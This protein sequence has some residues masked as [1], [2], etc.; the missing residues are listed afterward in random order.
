MID[1]ILSD[2]ARALG[3]QLGRREIERFSTYTSLLL[4][5]NEKFNLTA[6]TDPVEI[7]VKHHLDSL[8]CL[9]AAEFGRGALVADV[10][11]GAGFPGVPIAIVR[12]DLAVTLIEATKKKLIFLEEVRRR[13][14]LPHVELV[15]ARA[16]DVGKQAEY[17]EKYDI[18]L[19]RAV[20]V[21]RVLIEYSLP[22]VRVGGVFIA[23]KGPEVDGELAAAGPGIG[24]LGGGK[25][26]VV[27][28]TIPGT[29]IGRSMVVIKKLKPTPAHFPRSSSQIV[30]KPLGTRVG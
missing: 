24:T 20:S 23:Q 6:I 1:Q 30:R 8:T 7:A 13:L 22:L 28:L 4:E 25:P 10:G 26:D 27:R 3:I 2:G 5:W 9:K 19:A 14:E 21:M 15:H 29:D 11:T 18:V 17:R 16:E 12:P